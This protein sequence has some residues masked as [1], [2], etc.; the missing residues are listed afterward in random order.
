MADAAAPRWLRLRPPALAFA[1]VGGSLALHAALLAVSGS[2]APLGRAPLAGT[3]I[4]AIGLAW[5]LWA[6]WL[7]RAAGTTLLPSAEPTVLIEEGPYRIG[8]NP[9]YLGITVALLGLAL[10]LGVPVLALG[11]AG[12]AWVVQ[13]V[14]IP[15]EEA[16]LRRRFGGWYSDYAAQVRRWL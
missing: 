16:R 1:I 5:M 4:V 3:A 14:H 6:A 11:A 7:F 12:F 9:M 10:A 15:I 8:R 2:A 13:R